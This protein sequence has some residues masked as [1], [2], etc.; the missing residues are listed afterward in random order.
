MSLSQ[1][2]GWQGFAEP[3]SRNR[4]LKSVER[5]LGPRIAPVLEN[6]SARVT[7]WIVY[8][9]VH[10]HNQDTQPYLL[11]IAAR[12]SA[13]D[14]P[15]CSSLPKVLFMSPV[16]RGPSIALTF[17]KPA[18]PMVRAY[19]LSLSGRDLKLVGFRRLR[20]S[21]SLHGMILPQSG[22]VRIENGYFRTQITRTT[23]CSSALAPAGAVASVT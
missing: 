21:A 6:G 3:L 13:A 14:A 9:V 22:A 8:T 2:A 18:R 23:D 19:R 16:R 1:L 17:S 5:L 12:R 4:G 10:R 20:L 11:M 15:R 7:V